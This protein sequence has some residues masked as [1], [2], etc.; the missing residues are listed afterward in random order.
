MSVLT[1]DGC[2]TAARWARPAST[3]MAAPRST[4][5][6]P[7]CRLDL[8]SPLSPKFGALNLAA[9]CLGQCPNEVDPSRVCVRG[10]LLLHPRLQFAH[11]V[12]I[13]DDPVLEDDERFDHLAAD[14]VRDRYD[15]ALVNRGVSHQDRLDV[16]GAD[17]VAGHDDDVV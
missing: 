1:A 14:T 10:V 5:G 17:S 2:S 4:E 6:Y 16:E 9:R 11:Q 3:A 8:G 12:G 15:R 7:R 13:A